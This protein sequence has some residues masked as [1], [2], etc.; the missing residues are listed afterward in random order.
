MQTDKEY[1]LIKQEL[2][3]GSQRDQY[4]FLPPLFAVTKEEL[5]RAV[6]AVPQIIHFSGHGEQEG[7]IISKDDNTSQVLGIRAIQ[8]L[9]K[10]LQG[11]TKLVVLNSCYSANQAQAIS[12]FGMYVVGY[13]LPVEDEVA[14]DFARGL[15]IG[16][17][18]GNGFEQ[19]FDNAMFSLETVAEEYADSVE[20]WKDGIR[21]DM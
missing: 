21:K 14:I 1:R 16:L 2:E 8:R 12:K 15:Y 13:N 6:K 10:R 20:V 19:A 9:F 11:H 18:D 5:L 17:G 3:R 7:I 4:S